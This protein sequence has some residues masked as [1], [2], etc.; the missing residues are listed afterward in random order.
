MRSFLFL[1]GRPPYAGLWAQES[2]DHLLTVAAFDQ[3]VR[4]L[5]LDDGVFQ[6][7][8]AQRPRG[9][10]SV[11]AQLQALALYDVDEVFA[12]RE[13]LQERGVSTKDLVLPARLV[14]RA[15]VPAL[16]DAADILIA[17]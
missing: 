9:R 1:M 7:L 2:L 5:F 17:C 15:E 3:T 6:L 14:A 12:E 4:V 8:D 13:S 16:L 10:R 11:A